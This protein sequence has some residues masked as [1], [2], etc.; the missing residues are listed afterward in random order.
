[1]ARKLSML[2]EFREGIPGVELTYDEGPVGTRIFVID[3]EYTLIGEDNSYHPVAAMNKM[4][5]KLGL[6]GT[7]QP[8]HVRRT[9][10]GFLFF[11]WSLYRATGR[12]IR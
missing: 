2:E 7:S 3:K 8:L 9:S 10:Q 11:H 12:E 4:V 5:D 6:R 1:M